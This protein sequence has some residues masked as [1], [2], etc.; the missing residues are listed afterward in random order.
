MAKKKPASKT[1][2]RSA[3]SGEFVDADEAKKSPDTT[4]AEK[5]VA[6]VKVAKAVEAVAEA[7]EAK[8]DADDPRAS[9]PDPIDALNR[10]AVGK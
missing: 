3:V 5:V 6:A 4:V 2:T 9:T 1:R 7:V 8:G 10:P